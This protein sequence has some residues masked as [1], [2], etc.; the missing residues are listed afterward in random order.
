MDY[1]FLG[2]TSV[3]CNNNR[4]YLQT[5]PAPFFNGNYCKYYPE[6][7]KYYYKKFEM[8]KS[9]F[10]PNYCLYSAACKVDT[11]QNCKDG[12]SLDAYFCDEKM[13]AICEFPL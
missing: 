10:Y 3:L 4:T 2:L 12:W 13:R 8:F 6:T 5:H 9:K 7:Q 1:N 11:W